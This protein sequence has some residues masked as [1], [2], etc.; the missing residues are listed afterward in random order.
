MRL[1]SAV[2]AVFKEGLHVS[3][4]IVRNTS[5][6]PNGNVLYSDRIV[7]NEPGSA[8]CSERVCPGEGRRGM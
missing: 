6:T 8:L 5:S 3:Y 7:Y 4:Q 1:N 2:F